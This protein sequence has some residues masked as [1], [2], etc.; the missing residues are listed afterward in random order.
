MSRNKEFQQFYTKVQQFAEADPTVQSPD[1]ETQKLKV[2]QEKYVFLAGSMTLVDT[3][4]KDHCG[5]VTIPVM[6]FANVLYLQ[7]HSPYT[8]MISEQ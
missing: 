5:L 3:W 2:L 8:A 7:K 4:A 6:P 1:T